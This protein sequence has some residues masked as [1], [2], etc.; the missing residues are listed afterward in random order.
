MIFAD[1]DVWERTGGGEKEGGER[2]MKKS[3]GKG[4]VR[5]KEREIRE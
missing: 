3:E 4:E 1:R 5:E 2:E